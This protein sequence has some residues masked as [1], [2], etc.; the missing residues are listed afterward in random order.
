[1]TDPSSNPGLSQSQK[2]NELFSALSKAQLAMGT[3]V[4][5]SGTNP[6]YRSSYAT[7]LSV[8]EVAREPLAANGLCLSQ[9]I[10]G[11]QLISLLGHESGQSISSA[12]P[13]IVKDRN[14]PQSEGSGI[15]YARRY[16]A[17]AILGLAPDDDDGNEATSTTPSAAAAPGKADVNTTVPMSEQIKASVES[18]LADAFAKMR[19]ARHITHLSNMWA[20]HQQEWRKSLSDEDD[21]KLVE[22]KDMMKESLANKAKTKSKVVSEDATEDA[23]EDAAFEKR[24]AAEA[25]EASAKKEGDDIPF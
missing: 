7:L 16:A 3:S 19:D 22:Y 23:T 12:K 1:M 9:W 11:D 20:K 5:A 17:M 24:M 2:L 4:I 14:N 18:R 21:K 13:I 6:H 8:L 15:T 10:S 25:Q